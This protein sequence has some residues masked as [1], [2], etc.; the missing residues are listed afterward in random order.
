M[1]TAKDH[2]AIRLLSLITET[3]FDAVGPR[4]QNEAVK[5]TE[6][7]RK[8]WDSL[9]SVWVVAVVNPDMPL[10]KKLEVKQ[11]L[12]AWDREQQMMSLNHMQD[13]HSLK[14][15]DVFRLPLQALSWTLKDVQ[16]M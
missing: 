15:E 9:S 16:G 5:V 8:L 11:Q 10:D 6:K 2:N 12:E 13:S 3:F 7:T 4:H 14:I 1:F